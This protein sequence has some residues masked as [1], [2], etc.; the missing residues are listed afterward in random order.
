[1]EGAKFQWQRTGKRRRNKNFVVP[2]S[3]QKTKLTYRNLFSLFLRFVFPFIQ[4]FSLCGWE[5]TSFRSFSS[6]TLLLPSS[7]TIY[8]ICSSQ[9]SIQ[10]YTW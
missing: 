3:W 8:T 9:G 2:F 4:K 10:T 7:Y 6:S 1:M 5:E